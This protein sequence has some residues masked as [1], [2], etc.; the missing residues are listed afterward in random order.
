MLRLAALPAAPRHRLLLV[1]SRLR[2]RPSAPP[3]LFRA[4]SSVG[5]A[6]QAALKIE[7]DGLYL[8]RGIFPPSVPALAFCGAEV[9][10][11]SNIACAPR[12]LRPRCSLPLSPARAWR[13]PSGSGAS[14]SR[15]RVL[16]W[17]RLF[18]SQERAR[19]RPAHRRTHAL[20][21]EYIARVACAELA[22]PSEAAMWEEVEKV[23]AWK[24]SW[25]PFTP[26]RASLVLLHQ[27]RARPD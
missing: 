6:A 26:S 25:M 10:T 1:A 24:R 12:T 16:Q 4:R 3:S 5:T 22:L 9:A 17:A 27:V 7:A 23:K 20:H 13:V 18:T 19:V 15:A 2:L 11:I 8:Y 21:A 14:S